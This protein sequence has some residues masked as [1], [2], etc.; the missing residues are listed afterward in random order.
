MW[1]FDKGYDNTGLV[2]SVGYIGENEK[3]SF[4]RCSNVYDAM[5]LVN[6]LNGG[7]GQAHDFE[8]GKDRSGLAIRE[9]PE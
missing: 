3:K 9:V 7:S 5:K 2:Y 1:I 6:Y 4:V 8:I